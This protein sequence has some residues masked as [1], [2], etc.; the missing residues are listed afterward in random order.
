MR[1]NSARTQQQLRSVDEKSWQ[2]NIRTTVESL[3]QTEKISSPRNGF[4]LRK[5][6]RRIGRRTGLKLSPPKPSTPPFCEEYPKPALPFPNPRDRA[7]RGHLLASAC[8]FVVSGVWFAPGVLLFSAGLSFVSDALRSDEFCV[9]DSLVD[10]SCAAVL[11]A[12]V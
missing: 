10:E 6:Y 1:A 7:I 2:H 11:L 8:G 3:S 5:F 4:K 12:F 9:C